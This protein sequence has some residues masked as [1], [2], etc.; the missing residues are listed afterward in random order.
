V[1]LAPHEDNSIQLLG[2]ANN[3]SGLPYLFSS[4][5]LAGFQK[6]DATDIIIFCDSKTDL[7]LQCD[8][9]IKFQL[10]EVAQDVF[11]RLT[12]VCCML[13]PHNPYRLPQSYKRHVCVLSC[14]CKHRFLWISLIFEHYFCL[15]Y[16]RTA[17]HWQPFWSTKSVRFIG[18]C[19]YFNPQWIPVEAINKASS[20]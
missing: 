14:S 5:W 12:A 2:S 3:Y 16:M 15:N 13:L 17:C 20:V 4:V 10:F 18:Q 1:Y 6:P 9:Y 8:Y 7:E 11:S 19:W